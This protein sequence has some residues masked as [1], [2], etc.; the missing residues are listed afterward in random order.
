MISAAFETMQRPWSHAQSDIRYCVFNLGDFLG[1]KVGSL[2]VMLCFGR[3]VNFCTGRKTSCY[4]ITGTRC[5]QKLMT[6]TNDGEEQAGFLRAVWGTL[7]ACDCFR[8]R[9]SGCM[10]SRIGRELNDT[11]KTFSLGR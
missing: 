7:P 2:A 11:K 4:Q 6:S 5:A 10:I 1:S 9:T 3:K 8:L